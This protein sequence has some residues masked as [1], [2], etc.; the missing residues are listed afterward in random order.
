[1]GTNGGCAAIGEYF[2][3]RNAVASLTQARSPWRT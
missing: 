1:L 2:L 3:M